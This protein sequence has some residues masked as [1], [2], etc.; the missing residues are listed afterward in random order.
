MR[1]FFTALAFVV[2]LLAVLPAVKR[3]L[4]ASTKGSGEDPGVNGASNAGD[5]EA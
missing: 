2:M 3:S 1:T 4:Y 5:E